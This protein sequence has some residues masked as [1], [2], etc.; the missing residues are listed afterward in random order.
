MRCPACGDPMVDGT[1]EG[2]RLHGCSSCGG[3]FIGYAELRRVLANETHA[4]SES[5]RAASMDAAGTAASVVAD[6]RD[7]FAC[8]VCADP[9]RRYVHQYSS[10]IWVDACESHGVWLDAGELERL[11]AYAEAVA[12]GATQA[13][14]S[15]DP[16]STTP[17][18]AR[19]GALD[20][21]VNPSGVPTRESV[22]DAATSLA[23]GPLGFLVDVRRGGVNWRRLGGSKQREDELVERT[24][25]E[26]ES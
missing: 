26:L 6:G 22:T 7:P 24:R 9:M 18:I 14:A 13:P 4:R 19:T 16:R 1:H 23:L 20:D 15:I 5:E 21:V 11:E 10:G 12:R 3:R 17:R 8:P 2:E 25:R